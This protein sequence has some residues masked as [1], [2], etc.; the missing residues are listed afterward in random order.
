MR[1]RLARNA[2]EQGPIAHHREMPWLFIDGAWRLYGS[3][4]QSQ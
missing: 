3:I 1:S 4:N 2:R